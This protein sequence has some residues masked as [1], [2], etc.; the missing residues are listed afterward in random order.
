MPPDNVRP[1]EKTKSTEAFSDAKESSS[2]NKELQVKR[3]K[4]RDRAR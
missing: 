2:S 3:S 4:A 1:L